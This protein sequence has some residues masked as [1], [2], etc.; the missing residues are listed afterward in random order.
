MIE[1]K[2]LQQ[3]TLADIKPTSLVEDS[4][5]K[6][7]NKTLAQSASHEK[8]FTSPT[9]EQSFASSQDIDG[10][11]EDASDF[12][13]DDREIDG[14]MGSEGGFFLESN[15][16]MQMPKNQNSERSRDFTFLRE[17]KE[18]S[19]KSEQSFKGTDV[20]NL[21]PI[22]TYFVSYTKNV[23]SFKAFQTKPI[24]VERFFYEPVG[25]MIYERA[26]QFIINVDTELEVPEEY[27]QN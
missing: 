24:A 5:I 1:V 18:F 19:S 26:P 7:I 27:L 3:P 13:G 16:A 22:D 14:M 10:L 2:N 25:N 12:A 21:T 4:N 20:I 23:L 17:N 8:A 11:F 15:F 6:T 9:V